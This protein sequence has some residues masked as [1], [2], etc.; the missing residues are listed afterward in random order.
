M[1]FTKQQE[2]RLKTRVKVIGMTAGPVYLWGNDKSLG[3][4][5][6][7]KADGISAIQF[8]MTSSILAHCIDEEKK[9]FINCFSCK[10]F[11]TAKAKLYIQKTVGGSIVS[12]TETVRK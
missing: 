5:H 6:D 4:M 10:D 7:P 11:D 1:D 8:I 2:K 9:V 3:T 12:F